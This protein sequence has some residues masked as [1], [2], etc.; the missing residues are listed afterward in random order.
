MSSIKIKKVV[1]NANHFFKLIYKG[2]NFLK[3]SLEIYIAV[4]SNRIQNI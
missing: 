4:N 2:C 3:I 1:C